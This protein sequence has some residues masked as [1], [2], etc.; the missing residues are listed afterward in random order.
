MGSSSHEMH[1]R[2]EVNI[3]PDGVGTMAANEQRYLALCSYLSSGV[4]LRG[5]R[6]ICTHPIPRTWLRFIDAG[7]SAVS[8]VTVL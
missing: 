3:T 4:N 2:T 8:C 1:E 5:D 6:L 7:I